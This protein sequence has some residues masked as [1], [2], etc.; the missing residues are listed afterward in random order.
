[1]DNQYQEQQ[2]DHE[3]YYSLVAEEED[4]TTTSVGTRDS[5]VEMQPNNSSN[6][7]DN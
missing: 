3:P 2:A 5:Y 4:D 7:K 1:L 6:T